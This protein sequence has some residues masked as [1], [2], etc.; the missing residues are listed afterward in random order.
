M[1]SPGISSLIL[2]ALLA[3]SGSTLLLA[4]SNNLEIAML[5]WRGETEAE[6]GFQ[7]G[8]R[9]LGYTVRYTIL[10]ANQDK[11]ELGYLLREL[12]PKLQEFD[13]IYTFGTT[14]SKMTR[15]VVDDQ[16]P[17]IFNLVLIR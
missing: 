4:S 16:V 15:A 8:L 3:I 17:Q 1:K 6:A 7:A 14:V 10:N 11:G 12:R 13:Y 9:K 2:A 5:L